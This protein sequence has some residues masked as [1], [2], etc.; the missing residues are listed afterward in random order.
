M[1]LLLAIFLGV[2]VASEPE[3]R[4]VF[5]V[6]GP[7][8]GVFSGFVIELDRL[9]VQRSLRL[10]DDGVHPLDRPADG[11]FVASDDDA[12]S[13]YVGVHLV[14][15]DLEG[16]EELLYAGTV[17]TDD[18]RT[19]TVGWEVFAMAEGPQARLV[20]VARPGGAAVMSEGLPL[21]VAFGW[22]LLVLVFVGLLSRKARR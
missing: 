22:G 19:T 12:W 3:H 15:I 9:G 17:R 11:V 14:G 20:P 4:L 8:R 18:T 6:A 10:A 7:S 1:G 13:R 5:E 16:E 2:A 21:I